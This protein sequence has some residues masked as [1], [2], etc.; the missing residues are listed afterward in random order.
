[1]P[2][3]WMK[4]E[5]SNR[6]SGQKEQT[7]VSIKEQAGLLR[8]LGY[9]AKYATKRCLADVHWQFEGQQSPLK[10]LEV[11]KVVAQIYS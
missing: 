3:E 11:K 9:D 8:R 4:T 1:M 7:I 6:S 2:F 10:D 5:I